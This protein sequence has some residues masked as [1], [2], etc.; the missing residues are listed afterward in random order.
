MICVI[1]K[2]KGVKQEGE[3]MPLNENQPLLSVIIPVY[4][5]EKFLDRCIL[6]VVNQ[7]YR[8]L[9]II[10]VDDGST[11]N[12]ADM[13]DNWK[14]S[15]SRVFVHHQK[16]AGPGV[17][18]NTGI[19]LRR[20]EYTTFVDSDDWIESDMYEKM[21]EAAVT[22]GSEIVGCPSVIDFDDGTH[23]E[24]HADVP[25]G[26]VNKNQCIIDF[27]EGNRH[28][29]GAVHNK[30]YKSGL[31]NNVRFPAV[32]HLEDYVVSSKLFNEANTVYFCAHPYYHHTVN[33]ASLS[34]SG[35]SN[36]WLTI[37]DTTDKIVDY[38]RNNSPDSA[39][40]KA[41]YRFQ[42]LMDASVL[43]TLYRAKPNDAK[44]IRRHLRGRSINGF[45]EYVM[46]A[47]KRKGD[48]KAVAKYFL[49]LVG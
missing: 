1:D 8:N 44:Q 43:W 39:V 4:N 30:I 49:S 29:W 28:A 11:D 34:M 3:K 24:N 12:S 21:L 9:E 32:N 46:H 15:D 36:G 16:N 37:P 17:A 2:P 47:R 31:W 19:E 38:L 40:I 41:T 20:G 35:W 26:F 5:A 18:R 33:T 23:R 25:E 22:T 7:T 6:S 27:L 45:Q 48:L 13:C 10:L 42:F 14:E